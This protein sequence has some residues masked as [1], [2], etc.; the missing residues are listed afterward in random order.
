MI[1]VLSVQYRTQQQLHVCEQYLHAYCNQ[2]I[3]CP[4][5]GVV[6]NLCGIRLVNVG[7]PLVLYVLYRAKHT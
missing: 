5:K 2:G 7:S 1:G 4:Y 3:Y 6:I